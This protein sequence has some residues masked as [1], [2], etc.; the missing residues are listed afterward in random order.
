MVWHVQSAPAAL[1]SLLKPLS[2]HWRHTKNDR[3]ELSMPC[4]SACIWKQK[5]SRNY[6]LIQ[7]RTLNSKLQQMALPGQLPAA[8]ITV[9]FLFPWTQHHVKKT[10][11]ST[12]QYYL[13]KYFSL[14]PVPKHT[15]L[16]MAVADVA[17]W[18]KSEL[19]TELKSRHNFFLSVITLT[20]WQQRRHFLLPQI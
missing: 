16:S 10:Q 19:H 2:S 9:S 3:T 17:V 5:D 6:P 20:S 13:C 8:S 12:F 4:F 1:W 14:W 15:F 11:K 7:P 18:K